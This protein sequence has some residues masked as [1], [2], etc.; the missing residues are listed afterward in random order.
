M[1][2]QAQFSSS[3]I[4]FKPSKPKA[5]TLE[6]EELNNELLRLDEVQQVREISELAW[7]SAYS[8]PSVGEKTAKETY[9]IHFKRRHTVERTNL[10]I[11]R[12]TDLLVQVSREHSDG[13][14]IQ[15]LSVNPNYLNMIA[16]LL[17]DNQVAILLDIADPPLAKWISQ[18]LIED[19]SL[20]VDA[21]YTFN[22]LYKP[23]TLLLD[24]TQ[25]VND[26]RLFSEF[27]QGYKKQLPDPSLF[28]YVEINV[29]VAP[30]VQLLCNGR[31]ADGYTCVKIGNSP[32]NAHDYLLKQQQH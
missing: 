23:S 11:I 19:L 8:L 27:Q 32:Q 1:E 28:T 5:K 29:H 3:A 24:V 18:T 10:Y 30:P 15:R 31:L 26:F 14:E 22:S 12:A 21:I 6:R 4:N 9:R 20:K 7:K 16:Q 17:P 2:H 13:R 25:I